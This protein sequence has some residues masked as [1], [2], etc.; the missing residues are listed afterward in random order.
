MNKR[1]RG[2][3][4][5]AQIP[6]CV[7]F[8]AEPEKALFGTDFTSAIFLPADNESATVRDGDSGLGGRT[9]P[10]IAPR[11]TASASFAAWRAS[12]VSGSPVLS[13]EACDRSQCG[14]KKEIFEH[15]AYSTQQVLVKVEFHVGARFLNGAKDL[16]ISQTCCTRRNPVD[17]KQEEES[18]P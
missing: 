3:V 16:A 2:E 17:V 14:I 1:G 4:A 8:F 11:N 12:S 5:G 9:G 13:I 15:P 7:H 18:I 10:P 6:E